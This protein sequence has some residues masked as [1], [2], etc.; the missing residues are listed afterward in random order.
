VGSLKDWQL[1]H[2]EMGF[3]IGIGDAYRLVCDHC[4]DD[5]SLKLAVSRYGPIPQCDFCGATGRHGLDVDRLFSFMASCIANEWEDPI[6]QVGWSRRDGGWVGVDVIDTWDLLE[7]IGDPFANDELRELFTASFDHEWCQRNP[8]SLAP[9]ER[10]SFGW[11]QFCAYVRSENRYLFLRPGPRQTAD[12]DS[13]DPSETLDEVGQAI[14]NLGHRLLRVLPTGSL[15]WRGRTHAATEHPATA[16]ELGSPPS[17]Q[18]RSTRM[19]PAGI[20]VFY[21]AEDLETVMR[22]VAASTKP[23][24]TAAWTT[25]RELVYLDLAHLPVTPGLFD[26][27]GRPERPWLQFV[28]RFALEISRP[29]GDA[30]EIDYVPSQIFTEYVRRVLPGPTG[31]QVEGI[32]FR[33]SLQPSGVCWVLFVSSDGCADEGDDGPATVVILRTGSVACTPTA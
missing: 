17:A 30:P 22:E 16:A 21:A 6:R 15:L 26:M 10:L 32:R 12:P 5:P 9:H 24:T 2:D 33:S 23:V 25:A 19:S 13:I 18:T 14:T 29:T 1:A 4:I 28:H 11:E 27:P 31:R 3:S 8:Y 7:M 20:S